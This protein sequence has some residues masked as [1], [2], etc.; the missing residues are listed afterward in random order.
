MA[1]MFR[2]IIRVPVNIVVTL[3]CWSYFILGYIL[4]FIPIMLILIP[5]ARD[6][7]A[8]FQK[9]QHLCYRGF[10][11]LLGGITP[12]LSFKIDD[13][14]RRVRSAIVVANHRSYLDPIL[15]ISLFPRQ[16]TIVKGIFFSIPI[17]RW[18]MRSG[19][20]IPYVRQGKLN[21]LMVEGI[22]GM[23]EFLKKGGVFFVFPEGRRSRT[24]E[25][26]P[27]QKGAFSI[28]G[29]CNAP[30]EVLYINNTDRLFVPGKFFFNTCIT[31]IISV[32]RLGTVTP[33]DDHGPGAGEKRDEARMLVV[34][35]M[36]KNM[37]VGNY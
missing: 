29:K 17:M 4:F 36:Q 5:F 6:R 15:L 7:E 11:K 13:E 22:Q 31:N 24:G 35:R 1:D 37:P 27:F 16:K 14:V 20:Y 34:R 3:V 19:G 10:F 30:V 8:L 18:V 32:E 2:R 12:G 21:D 26:G 23:A 33:G 9:V 25:L 28:A